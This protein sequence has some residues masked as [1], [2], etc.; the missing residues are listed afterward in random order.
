MDTRYVDGVQFQDATADA[1]L[2]GGGEGDI[3]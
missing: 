2:A 1:L 3:G